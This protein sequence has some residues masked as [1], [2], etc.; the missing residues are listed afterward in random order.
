MLLLEVLMRFLHQSCAHAF[1]CVARQRS[2]TVQSA[3]MF[4]FSTQGP[5]RKVHNTD[6][7][8]YLPVFNRAEADWAILQSW[9]YFCEVVE[10]LLVKDPIKGMI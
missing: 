2:N 3:C 9:V 7:S 10:L 6:V 5:S 4:Y 8:D 1:L